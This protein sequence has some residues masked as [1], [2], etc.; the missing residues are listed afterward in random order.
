MRATGTEV[1]IIGSG[2]QGLCCAYSLVRR[3]ISSI[4][5][6]DAQ[7]YI[8]G[9]ST[10]RSAA[11][12]TSATG[13][14]TTTL[15]ADKSIRLYREM[16]PDL[17]KW[18]TLPHSIGRRLTIGAGWVGDRPIHA[19]LSRSAGRAPAHLPLFGGP[20]AVNGYYENC[21]A[22]EFGVTLGPVSGEDVARSIAA[23]L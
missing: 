10:K 19:P 20:G 8:G 2:I 9:H 4:I 16:V 5:V 15:L 11:M 17:E 14:R 7:D 12:L 21:G 3:G 13:H 22:G 18:T 23:R 6:L 1:V